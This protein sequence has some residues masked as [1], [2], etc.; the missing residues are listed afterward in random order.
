[1]D[2]LNR[3]QEGAEPAEFAAQVFPHDPPGVRAFQLRK[4]VADQENPIPPK[5]VPYMMACV[6]E[7]DRISTAMAERNQRG[8]ALEESGELK[9]AVGLYERNVQGAFSGN[10]PYERLQI[11]YKRARQY[12]DA[13]RVCRAFVSMADRLLEL[14]SPR[15]DLAHKRQH[16][17]EWAAR[18][19]HMMRHVG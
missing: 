6:D 19:N 16:F 17:S 14:G 7:A 13:Q 18:L 12:A 9:A 10:F 8:R 1:M 15:E 3:F 11:I 4:W 5:L 2:I